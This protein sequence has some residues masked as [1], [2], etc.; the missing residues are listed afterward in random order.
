MGT[1]KNRKRRKSGNK[2]SLGKITGKVDNGSTTSRIRAAYPKRQRKPITSVKF[3][4]RLASTDPNNAEC[5]VL[6]LLIY[7]GL[8]YKFVGNAAFIIQGKCPD[9]IHTEGK[10]K[11]IELFG[12]RWHQPE[13]EESRI[14]F[15]TRSGYETLIIWQKELMIKNRKKLKARLLAFEEL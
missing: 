15:F 2:K 8:P 9:F 11:I 4:Q 13:E 14:E 12:E 6:G 5:Q 1:D 10:M 7:M 3:W